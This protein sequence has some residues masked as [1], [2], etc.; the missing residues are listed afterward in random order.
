[1]LYDVEVATSNAISMQ[2]TPQE[3]DDL[4]A[5]CET[6]RGFLSV[7]EHR[8]ETF[9]YDVEVVISNAMTNQSIPR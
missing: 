8:E 3:S 1:M 7:Q 2:R 5:I 4:R 9:I 6:P